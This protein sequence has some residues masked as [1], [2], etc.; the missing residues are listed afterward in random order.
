V[1]LQRALGQFLQELKPTLLK[2]GQI[3]G[4]AIPTEPACRL[5]HKFAFAAVR[6]MITNAPSK[7]CPGRRVA[8]ETGYAFGTLSVTV[9]TGTELHLRTPSSCVALL[10]RTPISGDP[11]QCG[12]ADEDATSMSVGRAAIRIIIAPSSI[13]LYGHLAPEARGC[14]V[15]SGLMQALRQ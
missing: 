13:G 2:L 3:T 15:R 9:L 4:Q 10:Q 1:K 8:R 6:F 11:V 5:R 7:V 14:V 12:I